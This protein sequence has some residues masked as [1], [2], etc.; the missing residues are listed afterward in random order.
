[1]VTLEQVEKLRGY[2]DI[3]YDEAKAALEK[4]GGDL[5][6]AIIDLEKTGKINPPKGGGTYTPCPEASTLSDSGPS[7]DDAK[8]KKSQEDSEFKKNMRG[9][10]QW[11]RGLFHKGNSNA[12]VVHR[13][14]EELMRLPITLLILLLIFMFWIAVPLLVI[15]LFFNFRYA[16]KG[17]DI[18]GNKVNDAMD[19]VANAAEDIKKDIPK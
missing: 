11:L 17:P 12:L 8:G 19:S 16:F 18:K 2:A 13:H 7:V 5:L 15:G 10:G 1:M 9:L 6:Q 14:G 3:S 4:T